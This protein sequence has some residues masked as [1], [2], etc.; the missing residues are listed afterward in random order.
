MYCL[1]HTPQRQVALDV[2]GAFAAIR[3]YI[4][5]PATLNK[6]IY[7]ISITSKPP[8][9]SFSGLHSPQA[10]HHELV[11]LK[12]IRMAVDDRKNLRSPTVGIRTITL[13]QITVDLVESRL[14]GMLAVFDGALLYLTLEC[15]DAVLAQGYTPAL[16]LKAKELEPMTFR[17][18]FDLLWI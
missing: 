10:I 3:C 12:D 16:Y 5:S 7:S 1:F 2:S 6:P 18:I 13:I 4:A 14:E 15:L 9:P 17:D 11:K 8:D